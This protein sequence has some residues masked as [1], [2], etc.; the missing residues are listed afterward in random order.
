MTSAIRHLYIDDEPSIRELTAQEIGR[1]GFDV[2]VAATGEEGLALF[3]K[4]PFPLVTT[5]LKMPG[6]SGLD[7]LKAVKAID[8]DTEVLIATGY[9]SQEDA[10]EC[11]RQGAY[12]YL[13]KPF[14]MDEFAALLERAWGRRNLITHL[15][16]YECVRSEEHTSELQSP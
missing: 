14:H 6:M 9:G 10:I 15:A 12:D 13:Y 7:V 11:L 5:D 8:P 3:R 1:R 16:L 2:T 4:N